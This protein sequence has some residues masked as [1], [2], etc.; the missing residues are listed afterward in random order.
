MS[1]FK[2]PADMTADE[3][4]AHQ[5]KM[6][7]VATEIEKSTRLPGGK[8]NPIHK[9]ET[10]E[11]IA[12]VDKSNPHH[13]AMA[14]HSADFVSAVVSGNRAKANAARAAFHAVRLSSRGAPKGLEIPCS[15]SDCKNTN[16]GALSCS[17]SQGGSCETM[18]PAPQVRRARD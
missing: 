17:G 14:Q 3:A 2:D 5:V 4:V 8:N 7:G 1:D 6:R 12:N 18:S 16:K 10:R 11:D 13:V 15:G 9:H